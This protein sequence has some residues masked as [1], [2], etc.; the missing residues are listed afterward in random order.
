MAMLET[1]NHTM[2]QELPG[3]SSKHV[4]TI[5]PLSWM[6]NQVSSGLRQGCGE[7]KAILRMGEAL[8]SGQEL[9]A[10]GAERDWCVFHPW[11]GI[12]PCFV[13]FNH[14]WPPE[15]PPRSVSR[16]KPWH[17]AWPTGMMFLTMFCPAPGRS[18]RQLLPMES[19]VMIWDMLTR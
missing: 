16:M 18:Y 14:L 15:C 10:G 6:F 7:E 17:Q 1:L 3:R 11:T 19:A 5:S 9:P 13:F 2:K 4:M 8:L 12:P